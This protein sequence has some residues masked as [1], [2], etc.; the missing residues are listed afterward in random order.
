MRNNPAALQQALQRRVERTIV[1]EE[2]VFR[3]LL[4]ELRYAV[5]VVG[6]ALQAAENQDL[7]RALKEFERFLWIVYRR[8]STCL[9][10]SGILVKRVPNASNAF[11]E[12]GTGSATI[13]HKVNIGCPV[14]ARYAVLVRME[15]EP[16][17]WPD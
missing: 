2:F 14:G 1:D 9:R 6:R 11:G 17:H 16:M 15:L 4:E 7:E 5:G 12:H 13:S 10:L 3:L 8:H